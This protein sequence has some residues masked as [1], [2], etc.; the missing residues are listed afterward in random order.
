MLL[1]NDLSLQTLYIARIFICF[2]VFFY[3][4]YDQFITH[5]YLY[6][7]LITQSD[8]Y[9]YNEIAQ[10]ALKPRLVALPLVSA[11]ALPAPAALPLDAV[12]GLGAAAA[13]AVPRAAAAAATAATLLGGQFVLC[14]NNFN[15]NVSPS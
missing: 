15:Y 6:K 9:G 12:P 2:Y 5:N 1:S 11:S 14:N 13:P 3:Y 8:Y 10:C 7:Q 4:L